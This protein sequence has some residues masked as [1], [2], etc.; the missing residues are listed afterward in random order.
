MMV[1]SGGEIL[2]ERTCCLLGRTKPI[3]GWRGK[4]IHVKTRTT[5]IPLHGIVR[6]CD[7]LRF[8]IQRFSDS[9]R[10]DFAA[11]SLPDETYLRCQVTTVRATWQVDRAGAAEILWIIIVSSCFTFEAE[12]LIAIIL[13][14]R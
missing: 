6:I 5:A 14:A 1:S 11:R 13:E 2:F 12:S 8:V 3:S 9:S 4:S 7:S 10:G